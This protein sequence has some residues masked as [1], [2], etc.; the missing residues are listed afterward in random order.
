MG[1]SW[2]RVKKSRRRVKKLRRRM[3][4]LRRR[5]KIGSYKVD[6]AEMS[7]AFCNKCPS[8]QHIHKKVARSL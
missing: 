2:R 7:V 6:Y 1:V 4:K 8:T 3:K 5:V